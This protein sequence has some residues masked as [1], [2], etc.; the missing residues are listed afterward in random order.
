MGNNSLLGEGHNI[1]SF[2]IG[3]AIIWYLACAIVL[4]SFFLGIL[5]ND[6]DTNYTH[7]VLSIIQ[8]TNL[9]LTLEKTK[10]GLTK[11]K[12]TKKNYKRE[13][14]KNHKFQ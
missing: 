1:V 11:I 7:I 4:K 12:K 8:L 5:D 6:P 2:F 10:E 13:K 14:K 3:K 9:Y